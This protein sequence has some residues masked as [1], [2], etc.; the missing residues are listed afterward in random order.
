MIQVRSRLVTLRFRQWS[1]Q[2]CA[3]FHSTGKHVTIGTLK[4]IIADRLLGKQKTKAPG[5]ES[6]EAMPDHGIIALASEDPPEVNVELIIPEFKR[7]RSVTIACEPAGVPGGLHNSAWL[8]ALVMIAF[9]HFY[10]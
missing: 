10:F 3:A 2:S 7:N 8:K 1:R 6:G 5:A 4:T 9:S